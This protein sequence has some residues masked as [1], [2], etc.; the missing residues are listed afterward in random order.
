MERLSRIFKALSDPLRLRIIRQLLANGKE[1]YG[2]ELAKALAI[3]AYQLSRHLKVLKTTGLIHERREGRWVYYSVAKHNGSGHLLTA[4]RRL[5]AES[6]ESD[7]ERQVSRG[8]A[9]GAAA[10]APRHETQAPSQP[11]LDAAS[12][13]VN[14]DP[15]VPKLLS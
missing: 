1:A 14:W 6:V 15:T 2:E 4:L 11:S 7:G 13:P 8:R 10:R 3:P 12:D 9:K 5:M